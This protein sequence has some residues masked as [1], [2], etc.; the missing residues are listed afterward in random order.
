MLVAARALLFSPRVVLFD[1]ISLGLAPVIVAELYEILIGQARETGT[2]VIMVEEL[3]DEVRRFAD[4]ALL[5]RLGEIEN[6]DL[7]AISAAELVSA[8]LGGGST[9]R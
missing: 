1:E 8:Y 7:H 3:F 4:R 9:N 2:A 6:L 5:M